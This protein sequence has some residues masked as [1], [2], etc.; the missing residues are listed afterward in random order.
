MDF[1]PKFI[2]CTRQYFLRDMQLE[3]ILPHLKMDCAMYGCLQPQF[4]DFQF[5]WKNVKF[6][7]NF[8]AGSCLPCNHQSHQVMQMTSQ[9]ER[10]C[11]SIT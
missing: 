8:E 1:F 9:D 7:L 4:G 6:T 5:V 2:L 3:H 10:V 11:D